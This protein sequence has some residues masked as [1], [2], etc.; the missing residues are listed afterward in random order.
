M[1]GTL[2]KFFVSLGIKGQDVV[3]KNINK[4]KKEATGLSKIKA[5]IDMGKGNISKSISSMASGGKSYKSVSD[6]IS[7]TGKNNPANNPTNPANNPTNP[8]NNP[9][10]PANNPESPTSKKE[11]KN[12]D[13]FAK[14]AGVIGRGATDF[15][16]ASTTFDPVAVAQ[17]A[18]TGGG[19][20][21]GA[22]AALIPVVGGYLKDLPPAIAEATNAS[23]SM[24][25]GALEIAKQAASGQWGLQQR[26]STV[27]YYG[28]GDVNSE[29]KNA[30]VSRNEYATLMMKVASSNGQLDKSLK[31]MITG[32]AKTKDTEQ[33]GNVASGNFASTGTTKGWMMDQIMASL[34]NVPP[35]IRQAM[36]KPLLSQISGEMMGRKNQDAQGINAGYVAQGEEKILGE[37]DKSKKPETVTKL[38]EL[39]E[40]INNVTITMFDSGVGMAESITAA[41]KKIDEFT[42][43]LAQAKKDVENFSFMHVRAPGWVTDLFGNVSASVHK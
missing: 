23:I 29:A 28:G 21:L 43:A 10:N 31:E 6:I 39:S 17:H 7:K 19:K 24:G 22:V 3:L 34:G 8:A 5:N 13:K 9:T 35:E 30:G 15:L 32:L 26:N 25:V 33:L 14:G 1:S 11:E 20:L 27:D 40:A 4:I 41:A 36:M 42:K 16:K 37:Y 2:D 18:I 38:K 12:I